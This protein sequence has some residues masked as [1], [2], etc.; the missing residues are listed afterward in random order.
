[1]SKPGEW[2]DHITL[3]AAASV[4][5]LNVMVFSSESELDTI[6][7]PLELE[8]TEQ[9]DVAD[10]DEATVRD[11][12]VLGHIH[13]S[14]FVSTSQID[15]S[16]ERELQLSQEQNTDLEELIHLL[17]AFKIAGANDLK[18][19]IAARVKKLGFLED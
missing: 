18:P 10:D 16:T 8:A 17:H 12:I 15:A 6:V 7:E 5:Q 1:M 3:L 19:I 9:L 11:T 13:E 4:F 14:H 2:G